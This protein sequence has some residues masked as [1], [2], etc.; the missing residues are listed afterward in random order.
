MMLLVIL[1][2][3]IIGCIVHFL[4]N[5]FKDKDEQYNKIKRNFLL[6]NDW[7]DFSRTENHALASLLWEKG[8]KEIII[9][10]W[11]FLGEQLYKDLQGT[12][13][14]VKGIL[15]RRTVTNVYNTPTYNLKSK[16]PE[17]DAVIITVLYD[18]EKIKNDLAT[19]VKCP[20]ISLEDLV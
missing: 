14:K 13:I 17:V 3:I 5:A 16:L 8:Y 10:G 6:L 7:M 4:Y 15:D 12:Q 18:G 11:S 9:Y 19:V 2:A 20:A 1:F